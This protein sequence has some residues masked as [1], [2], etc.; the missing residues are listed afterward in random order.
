[1]SV[2][3]FLE[4][5]TVLCFC[6]RISLFL[7]LKVLGVKCDIYNFLKWFIKKIISLYGGGRDFIHTYISIYVEERNGGR[8]G[9]QVCTQVERA[10]RVKC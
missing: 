8:K 10:N 1:M 2:L 6:E 5:K 3:S 9:G 4:S 7:K